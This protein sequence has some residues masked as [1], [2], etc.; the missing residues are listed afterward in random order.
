MQWLNNVHLVRTK[1]FLW[2]HLL[3]EL[4]INLISYCIPNKSPRAVCMQI[5]GVLL[6]RLIRRIL[7]RV[8]RR[9]ARALHLLPPDP[10]DGD[11]PAL[12]LPQ[13]SSAYARHRPYE[14]CPLQLIL[15]P[16]AAYRQRGRVKK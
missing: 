3:N 11:S 4:A 16:P 6:S 10:H 2:R 9:C 13:D 14:S 5:V 15:H 7:P 12:P 1:L 8:L